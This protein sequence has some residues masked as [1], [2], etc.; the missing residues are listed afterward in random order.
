[1]EEHEEGTLASA[2]TGLGPNNPSWL[3][4]T[5]GTP[6]FWRVVAGMACSCLSIFLMNSALFPLFDEVFT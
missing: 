2:D 6:L 5:L 3:A 4:G 1:M